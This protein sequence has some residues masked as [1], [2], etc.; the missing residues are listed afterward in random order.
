MDTH[1]KFKQLSLTR[2]QT[3]FIDIDMLFKLI[4]V[5]DTGVGKTCLIRRFGYDEFD[6]SHTVTIGGDFINIF[7]LATDNK[8][9]RLQLWDT[10]GLEQYRSLVRLYFKGA[11]AALIAYSMNERLDANIRTWHDEIKSNT[12][13]DIPVYL[14]GTKADLGVKANTDE[15]IKI[16]VS[17]LGIVRHFETSAKE[18]LGMDETITDILSYLHSISTKDSEA[19]PKV[20]D[21]KV[22][23]RKSS[24]KK[25]KDSCCK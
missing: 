9:I 18:R 15:E 24:R 12:M 14:V 20:A 4:L 23:V 3:P 17:S 19:K 25:K 21:K 5:G 22:K 1:V 8:R 11:N 10:C 7:F 2:Q 6:S 16:L 13:S